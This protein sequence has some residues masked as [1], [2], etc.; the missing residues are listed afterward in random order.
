MINHRSFDGTPGRPARSSHLRLNAFQPL[1][2][3][4]QAT[5]RT[6]AL[7]ALAAAVLTGCASTSVTG[8]QR[9]VHERL[10]R[11][12]H[13]VIY[14][15]TAS[16]DEIPTNSMFAAQA[17]VPVTPPTEAEAALGRQLGS[18]ITSQ[19]I[20]AIQGMGL[21]AER[22][23]AGSRLQINDIVIRGYLVSVEQGSTAKRMTVGFG[24]GGSELTTAVEGFQMTAQGLRKLGAGRVDSESGKGPGA[25]LGA[26]GWLITGS[27][28]GLIVGGGMKVYGEASGSAKIEGRAQQTAAEIAD[29]L[30]VRFQ[31]EGWIH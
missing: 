8:R 17:S 22:G 6:L 19:L 25:S 21:P 5:V 7:G 26:A 20:L 31:E 12:E 15:F 9:Y 14:D 28:V 2:G 29:Q 27:P 30:K 11:P 3:G 13:I 18:S 4:V 10:P 16:A 24:S 23:Q 1:V